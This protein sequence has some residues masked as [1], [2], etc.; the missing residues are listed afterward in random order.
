MVRHTLYKYYNSSSTCVSSS[1][2]EHLL[3]LYC[4]IQISVIVKE[5]KYHK[6]FWPT[7]KSMKEK[8]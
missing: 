8:I 7:E 6:I 1:D 2:V 3:V 4:I 5:Y